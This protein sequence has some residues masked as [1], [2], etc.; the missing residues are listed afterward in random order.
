MPVSIEQSEKIY[1]CPYEGVQK[2]NQIRH[3]RYIAN[4][5]NKN[6]VD[7]THTHTQTDN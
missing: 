2:P 3:F 1:I 6:P 5:M 4:I 7:H